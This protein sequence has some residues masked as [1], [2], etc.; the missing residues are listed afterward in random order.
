MPSCDMCGKDG[1][2]A[3]AL[4]EGVE[5]SVC[6]RCSRHG[7]VVRHIR[8]ETPKPKN[9]LM[10]HRPSPKEEEAMEFVVEDYAQRIRQKREQLKL[11]Q[12]DFARMLSEKESMVHHLENGTSRP[13][14][15]LSRK[16]ERILHITLIEKEKDVPTEKTRGKSDALTLGD[17]IKIKKSA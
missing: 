16:L 9:I 8:M 12:Q 6:E 4:I 3:I 7:K 1:A 15:D 11:T 10:Q 14:I 13:S 17:F 5:L 2:I